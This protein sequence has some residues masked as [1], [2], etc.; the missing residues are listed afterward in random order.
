MWAK[1]QFS[2]I[3]FTKSSDEW[4]EEDMN[5]WRVKSTQ[6]EIRDDVDSQC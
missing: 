6:I 3:F 4:T 1:N 5:Q 2:G